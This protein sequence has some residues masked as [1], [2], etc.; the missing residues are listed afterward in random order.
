MALNS[1][2]ARLLLLFNYFFLVLLFL[3]EFLLDYHERSIDE[4]ASE[5]LALE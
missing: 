4:G 2:L 3:I 1:C 5:K